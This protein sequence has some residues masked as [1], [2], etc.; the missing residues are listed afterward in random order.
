MRT[1][2]LVA[3]PLIALLADWTRRSLEQRKLVAEL[4]GPQTL[5]QKPGSIRGRTLIG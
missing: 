2:L 1:L 3:I 5:D 4:S